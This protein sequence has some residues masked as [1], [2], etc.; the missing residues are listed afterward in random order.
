MLILDEP[1]NGLDPEGILWIRNLLKALAADGRTVF[2]SSHLMSEMA[3]TAEHL[4][5][6]GR[7][8]LIADLPIAEIVAQASAGNAVHVRSPEAGRLRDL[9]ADD[10]VTI[11]GTE[12]D[13]LEVSG[14]PVERIGEVAARE[15]VVLYELTPRSASLEEAF[16]ALTG[17]S[18]EYHATADPFGTATELEHAA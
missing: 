13:V 14:I 16:M 18:V 7:G 5:V 2:L 15:G 4:V 1:A 9:L 3:L 10:G 8:R 11:R 6:V 17:D 12:R